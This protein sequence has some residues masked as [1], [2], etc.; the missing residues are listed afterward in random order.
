METNKRK[1]GH[2]TSV[3]L[4]DDH[5]M[6]RDGL[7][8]MLLSL[9][10][11]IRLKVDEA[12]SGEEALRKI[13]R[14]DFDMAIIDYQMPELSGPETVC[15]IVRFKPAIKILALSNYDELAYIEGMMHAGANGFV[16]KNI[17]C[18]ELLMA[19]RTVLSGNT[20]FCN[21]V[22]LKIIDAGL[23]KKP[24]TGIHH[25][26]I[27]PRELEVLRLIAVGLTNDE[28]A[29]KLFLSKRTIDTHRQNLLNKL[30]LKNTAG[31]VRAAY[32]M[33]LLD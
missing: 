1:H 14:N 27:T 7:K 12:A 25:K 31:L 2:I 23:D 10:K 20:Y 24:H 28:I 17:G 5:E 16:L 22:A 32:E 4:I 30:G 6:V 9:K 18:G 15:R 26:T 3:L 19:V 29:R 13:A 8:V 11:D 21:S 33:K